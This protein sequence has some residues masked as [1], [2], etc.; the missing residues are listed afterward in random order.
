MC[1]ICGAYWSE[2]EPGRGSKKNSLSA[3]IEIDVLFSLVPQNLWLYFTANEALIYWIESNAAIIAVCGPRNSIRPLVGCVPLSRLKL[4]QLFIAAQFYVCLSDIKKEKEKKKALILQH[5]AA[6]K[7]SRKS[8]LFC[9]ASNALNTPD[10]EIDL[11]TCTHAHTRGRTLHVD[12]IWIKGK[13]WILS[14]GWDSWKCATLTLREFVRLRVRIGKLESSSQPSQDAVESTKAWA[15][16]ITRKKKWKKASL[17][18]LKHLKK[19]WKSYVLH[20]RRR[21]Y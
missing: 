18:F 17:S 2:W 10:S 20:P 4:L 14:A 9:A 16:T 21:T 3:L 12:P 8:T 15:D 11:C 19:W 5:S 1:L 6:L 7:F 13:L